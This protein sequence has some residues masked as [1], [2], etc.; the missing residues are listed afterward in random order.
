MLHKL[1]S[2]V[3]DQFNI[4]GEAV[5]L[6]GGQETTVQYEDIVLKPCE[7][8]GEWTG[9]APILSQLE[10][11]GY[12]IAMPVQAQDGQWVVDGW[13]ATQF[14][15]GTP[16]YAGN[17]E[18]A[19]TACRYFHRDLNQVYS[20]HECPDWLTSEDSI[21]RKADKLAWGE[22][23]LTDEFDVVC[24]F[25]NPIVEGITPIDLPNQITH[26]D[27]GHDNVLFAPNQAPA[28][29]DIEPYWRPS[30]YA[31][32]MMLAD[33]IAWEGSKPSTLTLAQDEPYIGQLL[34]RAIMF[35]L[36]VS[37]LGSGPESLARKYSVYE[38]VL[39]WAFT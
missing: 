27:P 8:T 20:S 21:W 26:G 7:N 31:L 14:I 3:L 1:T 39:Q 30:G 15:E 38:P 10:P 36:T 18:E 37:V 24:E 5:P 32:A 28:I 16:G 35:R 25:L 6:P 29:I 2:Q 11:D 22:V 17:E 9:L 23:P 13:L 33:G 4:Q 19:L 12:R 34:L